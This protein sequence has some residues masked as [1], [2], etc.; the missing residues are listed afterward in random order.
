M[1][2]ICG[3]VVLYNPPK[4]ILENI[5]SYIKYLDKLYIIDNSEKIN[6]QEIKK[7]KLFS[8]KIE[9]TS[10][11]ENK[12]IGK[13]L[14]LSLKKFLLSDAEWILTMDQD[15]KFEKNDFK[16]YLDKVFAEDEKNKIGIFSPN[17]LL[18]N[19]KKIEKNKYAKRVMCSGNIISK[20]IIKEIGKYNEDFFID[21]VDHEYCYRVL[22]KN[23]KIKVFGDIILNHNLGEINKEVRIPKFMLPT[24]HS[25]LRR[26][27]ITR[28]KMY[29]FKKYPEVRLKYILTFINDFFKIMFF[30]NNKKEKLKMMKIGFMHYKK[31]I[32]GKYKEA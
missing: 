31:N 5:E 18:K 6:E 30:E 26:Y 20:K 15:S 12:G 23:Y 1:E 10:F 16:I 11:S 4:S 2:K 13:A 32:V 24:N 7:I 27:Y 29:V 25:A 28:N 14:N 21:E 3:V 8:N 22:K 9:Y 17:H 19:K